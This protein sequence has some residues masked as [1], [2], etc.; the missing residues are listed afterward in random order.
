MLVPS[1]TVAENL[2]LGQPWWRLPDR[3]A[4]AA[5]IAD[6]NASLGLAIDPDAVTGGLSLGEQQQAEIVRA[7]LRG[8]R[9]LILDESTSMLTPQGR[10]GPRRA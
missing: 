10:R 1:L 8:S 3:A 7:L 2:A 9:V 5:R 6:M 4:L